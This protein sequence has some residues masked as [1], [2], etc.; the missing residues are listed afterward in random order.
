MEKVDLARSAVEEGQAVT[1]TPAGNPSHCIAD[2]CFDGNPNTR[3]SS[4][5]EYHTPRGGFGWVQVDLGQLC[6]IDSMHVRFE[7]ALGR[8]FD[9]YCARHKEDLNGICHDSHEAGANHLLHQTTNNTAL[10]CTIP[11]SRCLGHAALGRY[12]RIVNRRGRNHGWGFSIF[13]FNV[14]GYRLANL[15]REQM[16]SLL[17]YKLDDK[18]PE[19]L[20]A[21]PLE[22]W[23]VVFD[24]LLAAN[25]ED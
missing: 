15:R 5:P 9:I 7:A 3:F 20:W 2:Y 16:Y 1:S 25:L 4:C 22:I 10:T 14:Y 21:V 24:F 17:S 6:F 23:M 12:V 18:A 13:D 11:A 8:D 19:H